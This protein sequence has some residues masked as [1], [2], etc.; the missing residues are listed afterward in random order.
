MKLQRNK[1]AI[2][3][4]TVSSKLAEKTEFVAISRSFESFFLTAT[5]LM[6]YIGKPN[7]AN[8]V[9]YYAMANA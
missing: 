5:S 7:D 8:N 9:K 1:Y 2:H 6:P 3:T 4:K